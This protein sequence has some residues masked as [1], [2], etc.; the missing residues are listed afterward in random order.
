MT[1]NKTK[2][3]LEEKTECA[4][5]LVNV[6]GP[7]DFPQVCV[8]LRI[9]EKTIYNSKA[10]F[11]FPWEHKK[12]RFYNETGKKLAAIMDEKESSEFTIEI[13]ARYRFTTGEKIQCRK[14]YDGDYA[15]GIA[16][17]LKELGKVCVG[18]K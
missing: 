10:S 5:L 17:K 9:G 3:N 13:G 8:G 11:G 7:L 18:W 12:Y 4:E 1:E 15:Q 6:R 2:E 16:G 14:R